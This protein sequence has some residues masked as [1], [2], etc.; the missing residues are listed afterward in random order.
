MNDRLK[1]KAE[2]SQLKSVYIDILKSY[3]L[4]SSPSFGKF[5]IRHLDLAS[6]TLMDEHRENFLNKAKSEGLPTEKEQLEYLS[7]ENLW[8]ETQETQLRDAK[9]SIT[10][11]QASKSKVFLQ[12]Q[13]DYFKE[14]I[15]NEQKKINKL[16]LEKGELMGLTAESYADKKVNEF[17]IFSTLY[18]DM[19]LE[20]KFFKEDE[21]EDVDFE[22][23]QELIKAY[24]ESTK[25]FH[26]EN[27]KRIALST[28]FLNYFYLCEDNPMI[29]FGEPVVKLSYYQVELFGY[30]RH[31]KHLMS[32]LKSKPPDEYYDDPDKLI[33]YVEAGKSAQKMLERG[34]NKDREHTATSVIG[35]TKEDLRRMCLNKADNDEVGSTSLSKEASKKEGSLSMDD[36]I[37]IHEKGK[38]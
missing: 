22:G 7:E 35:A 21:F 20:D 33:E 15:Q 16:V 32:E 17:Y 26:S 25:L 11:L 36:L 12:K 29:F 14:Q 8:T 30:A 6:S 19:G 13:I 1:L 3:T 4:C 37:K 2:G 18:K 27:L 10:G 23:L 38:L 9:L 5:Y 34:K 28:F 24:N 31:F